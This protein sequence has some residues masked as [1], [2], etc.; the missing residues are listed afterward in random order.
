VTCIARTKRFTDVSEL[1]FAIIRKKRLWNLN[2]TNNIIR[3]FLLDCRFKQ[4]AVSGLSFAFGD[5]VRGQRL[6]VVLLN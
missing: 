2:E 4:Y 1:S 6:F 3:L 5:R